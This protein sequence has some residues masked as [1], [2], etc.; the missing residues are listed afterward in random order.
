MLQTQRVTLRLLG[1]LCVAVCLAVLPV[2]PTAVASFPGTDLLS[3]TEA[4]PVVEHFT[5]PGKIL[6]HDARIGPVA[7]EQVDIQVSDDEPRLAGLEVIQ[8]VAVVPGAPGTARFESAP[9]Q[10]AVCP[11]APL[12]IHVQPAFPPPRFQV[13]AI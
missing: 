10:L 5:S 6:L 9:A 1:L 7:M 8:R 4:R 11:A 2:C 13:S 12:G 3:V